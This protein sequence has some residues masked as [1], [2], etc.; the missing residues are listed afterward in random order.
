M[1][2]IEDLNRFTRQ[3][4]AGT[5]D[6]IFARTKVHCIL[7]ARGSSCLG[8]ACLGLGQS[9]WILMLNVEY[10]VRSICNQNRVKINFLLL[11]T[12]VQQYHVPP[13]LCHEHPSYGCGIKCLQ[14]YVDVDTPGGTLDSWTDIQLYDSRWHTGG[15]GTDRHTD[16][17][18]NMPVSKKH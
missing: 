15:D 13:V 11:W 4:P 14:L 16:R 2:I 8:M 12:N 3:K 5:F 17:H 10:A 1:N 9:H 7:C 18:I 6:P